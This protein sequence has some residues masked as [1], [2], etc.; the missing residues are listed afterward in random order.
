MALRNIVKKGDDVL[1]KMCRPVEKFDEKLCTLL[2]DMYETMEDAN[3]VGLPAGKLEP[4]EDPAQS[5]RRE[6]REETGCTAGRFA[7]PYRRYRCRRG[8]H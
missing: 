7:A 5:G 4:G 3:G 6:L 2:D 1:T 8:P